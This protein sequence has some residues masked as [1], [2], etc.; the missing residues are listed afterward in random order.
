LA[1]PSIEDITTEN[2]S[3][4]VGDQKLGST[5]TGRLSLSAPQCPVGLE[6][7]VIV[8]ARSNINFTFKTVLDSEVTL[9][10]KPQCSNCSAY[11]DKPNPHSDQHVPVLNTYLSRR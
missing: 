3:S 8:P 4:W 9:V 7:R 6:P 2:W 1:N 11:T 10:F 5:G